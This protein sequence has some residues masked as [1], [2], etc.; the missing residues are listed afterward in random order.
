M[1]ENELIAVDNLVQSGLIV[2]LFLVMF[3]IGAV[4]IFFPNL[5]LQIKHGTRVAW[6]SF[7]YFYNDK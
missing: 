1:M 5:C 7:H 4:V 3:V 2:T 6:N